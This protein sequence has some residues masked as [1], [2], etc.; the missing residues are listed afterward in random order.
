MM[1]G[2]DAPSPSQENSTDVKAASATVD[3]VDLLVHQTDEVAGL[4]EHKNLEDAFSLQPHKPKSPRP[5]V[6][7]SLSPKSSWTGSLQEFAPH[8]VNIVAT[9]VATFYDVFGVLGVPMII[10]FIVSAAWTFM[11]AAIQIHADSIANAIM[12]T[13][14]FDNGE[15]W[16]LPKPEKSIVVSSVVLLTIFGIGYTALAVTMTFFYRAGAPKE[17]LKLDSI[18]GKAATEVV[19]KQIKPKGGL[20]QRIVVWIHE[21]PADIREHYFTA[22]LDLP[23][24]VF[25]TLTL[26]TYLRKGFPTAIIYY[27]S[28]LLLFNWLVTC[29]RSQHYVADPDLIIARLYYTFD[30][31]FAVFAPLV[32]LIYYVDTFD[33]DRAAFQTKMET[34]GVGSFDTVARIYGDPSQIS[35]F[36]SAF[37]YLQFSVGSTLFYKSALNILSLYKWR[38]IVM[39]LIHNHHE[40]QAERK[41]RASV[42][43]VQRESQT[44]II[45]AYLT[46]RLSDTISKPKL[47]QHFIPKLFLSLVFLIAGICMFVYS[48]GA[49]QSTTA[50]CSKY[51][52]C[53]LASYQWNYGEKDCTC[54]VFADRQIAPTTYAE[55]TNPVDTTSDL[56]ELA[57]AGELRIVQIINRAVPELPEELKNCGH[58]EQLILAYTKTEHLP[59]WVS[60]F[61]RLEYLHIEGDYTS[62]RLH[63]VAD[64]IFDTMSHLAFLHIGVHPDL[65]QVPS[66]SKLKNLRYL[67][68]AVMDS[69]KELPSFVGLSDVTDM[70][71]AY[72]PRVATLPSLQPLK[73]MQHFILSSRTAICCNGFLTGTCNMTEGQCLPIAG[74]KY[75]LTCTDE[76]I[77]A[78]DNATLA[79]FGGVVCPPSDAPFSHEKAAPTKYSTDELCNGVKYRNCKLNGVEGMCYNTRMMVINCSTSSGYIAMRKLQIQR[80]VGEPCDPVEEAWLGCT[81]SSST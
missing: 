62:R 22:A 15:F 9:E 81:N 56:A 39:T 48:I 40:R 18:S 58:L 5:S 28:V 8:V 11:M 13:T 65:E 23:K 36:C 50:L 60:E 59:E 17:D 37:H 32:V 6:R 75:P 4:D 2:D 68:L 10:M 66:L 29:Y 19:T 38:K 73:S 27:Y 67:A 69:L 61:S 74:E 25:Q 71:I 63:T 80:G 47:G 21:L 30:L 31:F 16:L 35:S 46:K 20:V 24:L 70:H 51:D 43:P 3:P 7:N 49:V 78:E 14:E 64:G 55:W 72:L 54:L 41:R 79:T 33:F 42:K 77:S 52:K 76:R 26:A 12:N 53:V 1:P 34:L 57:I 45:K 44:G